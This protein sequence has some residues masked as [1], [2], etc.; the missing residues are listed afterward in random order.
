[1]S[2]VDNDGQKLTKNV[3]TNLQATVTNR[4]LNKARGVKAKAENAKLNFF[5]K[6]QS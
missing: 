3:T 1:M 4:D 6:C 5:G 2:S